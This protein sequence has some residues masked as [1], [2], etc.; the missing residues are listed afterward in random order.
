MTPLIQ[1][2]RH[3]SD[4]ANNA[5]SYRVIMGRTEYQYIEINNVILIQHE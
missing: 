4:A 3:I 5:E 2:G 1:T